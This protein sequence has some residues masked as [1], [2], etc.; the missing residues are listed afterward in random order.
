MLDTPSPKVTKEE[1]IA[2][3]RALAPKFRERAEK[4]EEARRLPDESIREMV[5]AGIARILTP[6]RFGGYGLDLETWFDVAREIG[7]GDASHGWCAS[8]MIHHHHIVGCFPVEAQRAVWANGPDVVIA[9]AVQPKAQATREK[10]GYRVSGQSPSA[11]GV[12]HASWNIIGAQVQGEAAPEWM[13]FLIAPGEYTVTDT[14]FVSGM[15]ATGSNTIVTKDLFVPS[16]RA[17]TMAQLRD[18]TGPGSAIHESPIFRA[19]FYSWSPLT[20]VGP[21]LGAAQ[22]AY[23][24]FR[25]WV[26]T[27]AISRGGGMVA[28]KVSIQV[29]MARAAADL[30]M[31]DLLVRRAA[32]VPH[33]PEPMSREML[34]RNVRDLSRASELIVQGIDAIVLMSGA[35]SFASSNPI[36]R[37]WRDIHFAASHIALD[38]EVNFANFGRVELGLP[39][40]GRQPFL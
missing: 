33:A 10:G 20:F 19:P 17:I 23:D 40:D 37:A 9:A 14:W 12:T 32:K 21:M 30:D 13:F 34:A 25:E 1:I 22:G 27:R 8:L 5:D 7:K 6:V 4:A 31:A 11:S 26:K 24:Y 29:G 39:R 2:R 3:V 36:Q 38:P 35:A 18:G 28:D 15:R 16:T